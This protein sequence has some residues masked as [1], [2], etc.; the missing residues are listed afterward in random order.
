[1]STQQRVS[2]GDSQG[3]DIHGRQQDLVSLLFMD[4][5]EITFSSRFSV[6][7]LVV[8]VTVTVMMSVTFMSCVFNCHSCCLLCCIQRQ[9]QRQIPSLD[10]NIFEAGNHLFIARKLFKI[11]SCGILFTYFLVL[12]CYLT[13]FL[14]LHQVMNLRCFLCF[15]FEVYI[16]WLYY[17]G[18]CDVQEKSYI[19]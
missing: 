16:I 4:V 5:H 1:M 9:R 7:C 19:A 13:L 10:D 6:S 14:F 8:V 17:T 3:R 2:G 11:N 18:Q 15:C 12:L